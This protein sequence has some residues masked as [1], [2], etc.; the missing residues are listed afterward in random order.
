MRNRGVSLGAQADRARVVDK[1]VDRSRFEPAKNRQKLKRQLNL[2]ERPMILSVGGL[3]PRKGVHLLLEAA[4]RLRDTHDFSVVICGEGAE[5][6][7]LQKLSETLDI[8]NRT[9]F[10]GRVERD[11]MPAYFAA[12]D[13]FVTC[14]DAGGRG[15][16][17]P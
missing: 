7:R 6:E 2:P 9:Y 3:I 5:R 17:A 8:S 10:L 12:C 1:G 14:L 15:Q 11:T 13:V 4:A 16:R